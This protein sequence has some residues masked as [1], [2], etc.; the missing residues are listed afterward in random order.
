MVPLAVM[1]KGVEHKQ[2]KP[3]GDAGGYADPRPNPKAPVEEDAE[4]GLV[5]NFFGAESC[6]GL[7]T[8]IYNTV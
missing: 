2:S 7:D 4:Y 5:N 3:G 1:P 8:S 6:E